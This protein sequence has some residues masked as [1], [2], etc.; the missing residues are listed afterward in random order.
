MGGVL[1]FILFT[2]L[3]KNKV[4]KKSFFPVAEIAVCSIT[5]AH[6]VGRVGC[7]LAGCC[8]GKESSFGLTF[9]HIGTVIPTQ[10]YEFI[11]L[12][13]LTAVLIFLVLSDKL[14]G[15]NLCIYA[16]SYSVFRFIIEFFRG[17]PRGAFL[18]IFS[19]SQV[20]SIILFFVGIVLLI[21]RIKKQR[22]FVYDGAY[23][24]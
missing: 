10:L 24:K 22:L 19:P 20:Q 15:F 23:E 14:K 11:F 3:Q 9:P 5:L 16:L 4:I 6:A 8:Y 13:I 12:F 21:L 17:D 18:G 2:L 1:T 7:F